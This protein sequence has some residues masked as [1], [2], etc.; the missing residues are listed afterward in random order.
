MTIPNR[1]LEFAG[2]SAAIPA[3][4]KSTGF[5]PTRIVRDRPTGV[6]PAED[7]GR[8]ALRDDRGL[9]VAQ[10]LIRVSALEREAEGPEEPGIRQVAALG[11]RL[12]A[13]PDDRVTDMNSDGIF[14]AG[15][16]LLEGAGHGIGRFRVCE[17]VP[18]GRVFRDAGSIQPR[19]VRM[20]TV[21]A[22]LAT[23]IEEYQQAR[24]DSD[25]EAEDDDE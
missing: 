3:T 17:G 9:Q 19:G 25:G 18:L 16:A 4:V 23:D 11:E 10:D 13:P 24:R 21:E 8:C 14:D 2:G 15:Q 7:P 5:S 22:P 1:M 12:I 20:E 6:V